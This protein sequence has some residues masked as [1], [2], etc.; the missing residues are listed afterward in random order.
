MQNLYC[1]IYIHGNLHS[2]TFSVVWQLVENV[3]TGE[4]P[5]SDLNV[6]TEDQCTAD[7]FG[8]GV[9]SFILS[10]GEDQQGM[11]IHVIIQNIYLNLKSCLNFVSNLTKCN[12]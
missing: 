8:T 10:F 5:Q 6:C 12:H 2:L 9:G 7:G 11:R 1:G 4:W 3:D